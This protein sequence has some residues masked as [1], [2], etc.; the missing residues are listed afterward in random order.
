VSQLLFA[1][2]QALGP[3]G[4]TFDETAMVAKALLKSG[5]G[6]EMRKLLDCRRGNKDW[7]R[8]VEMAEAAGSDAFTAIDLSIAVKDPDGYAKHGLRGVY[9]LPTDAWR[10]DEDAE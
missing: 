10:R 5:E 9:P 6:D 1:A 2:F 3:G 7:E 8:C 4:H